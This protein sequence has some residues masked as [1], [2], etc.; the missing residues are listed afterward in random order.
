VGLVRTH[1]HRVE[2]KEPTCTLC[3]RVA[4][5]V[6][7]ITI[8]VRAGT[9]E[10]LEILLL[11]IPTAAQV[12]LA[13]LAL[14][15][16]GGVVPVGRV[17]VA[18]QTLTIDL[19]RVATQHVRRAVAI[20]GIRRAV[21]HLPV[22]AASLAILVGIFALRIFARALLQVPPQ[23]L[24]FPTMRVRLALRTAA[25]ITVSLTAEVFRA[26]NI[27]SLDEPGSARA[28]ESVPTEDR[29]R[30]CL[31]HLIGHALAV[32]CTS[33]KHSAALIVVRRSK[34]LVTMLAG[35]QE[36]PGQFSLQAPIAW[37]AVKAFASLAINA[38][39]G[40]VFGLA[41]NAFTQDRELRMELAHLP[42]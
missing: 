26:F 11:Q 6:A 36:L 31:Q 30:L 7:V 25:S 32:A 5:R 23:Q 17:L 18:R 40:F 29:R 24:E 9:P 10:I 33:V 16:A 27:L 14:H 42:L 12:A 19:T 22:L 20:V 21:A 3:I 38:A 41:R 35:A 1:R 28:F 15:A 4:T 37:L 13:R 2:S 8:T 34:V 39:T